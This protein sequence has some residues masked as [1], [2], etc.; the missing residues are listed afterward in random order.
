MCHPADP[1]QLE[2][3]NGRDVP[4]FAGRML[5]IVLTA[6]QTLL[7]CGK[8]DKVYGARRARGLGKYSRQFQHSG[9]GRRIV[10]RS[11]IDAVSGAIW[12]ADSEVVPM[13]TVEEPF[14]CTL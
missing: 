11:V 5:H 1:H 3:E 10:D 6:Q 13:R 14:L 9:D 4:K 8:S 2:V 12:L 7:L